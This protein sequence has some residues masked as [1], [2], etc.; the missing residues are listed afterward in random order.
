[1]IYNFVAP[2]GVEPLPTEPKSVVLLLYDRA[3]NG[4][5]SGTRTRTGAMPKGA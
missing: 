4:D 1:M 2:R 3:L 5:G